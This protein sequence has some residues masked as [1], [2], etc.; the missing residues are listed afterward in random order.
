MVLTSSGTTPDV[1]G[2]AMALAD[3]VT[4]HDPVEP[5]PWRPGTPCPTTCRPRRR[6]VHR[7][8]PVRRS[9]C[10]RDGSRPA[11]PACPTT[12]RPRASSSVEPDVYRTVAGR[13]I[14]ELLKI[15]RDADGRVRKMN[16]ATYLVTREPLAFGEWQA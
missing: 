12:S 4:D 6:L 5:E 15:T 2:F 8:Q 16:W 13:E 9:P 7:G 14:G 11:R 1:A 3:L 10:G